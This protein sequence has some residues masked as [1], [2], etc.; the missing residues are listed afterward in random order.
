MFCDTRYLLH[1]IATKVLCFC[2]ISSFILLMCG[3]YFNMPSGLDCAVAIPTSGSG[4][5]VRPDY[6]RRVSTPEWVSEWVSEWVTH[7]HIGVHTTNFVSTL[8]VFHSFKK[9]STPCIISIFS[10]CPVDLTGLNIQEKKLCLSPSFQ[11]YLSAK[12][13]ESVESVKN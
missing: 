4:G 7:L 1:W 10:F 2:V 6:L 11:I 8:R 3:F 9:E 13:F 12:V 5:L